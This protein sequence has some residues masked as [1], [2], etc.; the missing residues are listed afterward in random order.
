MHMRLWLMVDLGS[1]YQRQHSRPPLHWSLTKPRWTYACRYLWAWWISRGFWLGL[2]VG[3]PSRSMVYLLAQQVEMRS[4]WSNLKRFHRSRWNY[5]LQRS[6][7]PKG[8]HART[9][10]STV[11]ECFMH[12]LR[13][14][15][16]FS[17]PFW[18]LHFDFS[19]DDLTKSHGRLTW[20]PT[21]DYWVH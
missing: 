4:Y 19:S 7:G 2:D 17:C 5:L 16:M 3:A 9:K 6:H 10:N 12:L 18:T 13:C 14:A 15:S 21:L 1:I 8:T 20:V 11:I